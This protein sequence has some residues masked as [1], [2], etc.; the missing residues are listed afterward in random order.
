[1]SWNAPEDHGRSPIMTA[2]ADSA[3]SVIRAENAVYRGSEFT[4]QKYKIVTIRSYKVNRFE[5]KC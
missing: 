1:M 2:G 4:E 3:K 5:H